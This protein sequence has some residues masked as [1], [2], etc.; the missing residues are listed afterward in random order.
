MSNLIIPGTS[1]TIIDNSAIPTSSSASNNNQGTVLIASASPQGPEKLV[2]LTDVNQFRKMFTNDG[3]TEFKKFGMPLYAVDEVLESGSNVFF[4]RIVSEDA[5]LANVGIVAIVNKVETQKVNAQ[6]LPLYT[7][8]SGEETTDAT[9]V[10]VNPEYKAPV[11]SANKNIT[12]TTSTLMSLEVT[13]TVANDTFTGISQSD[14]IKSWFSTDQNISDLTFTVTTAPTGSN[15]SFTF[16]VGG[17]PSSD[18]NGKLLLTIPAEKI[19]KNKQLSLEFGISIDASGGVATVAKSMPTLPT[20]NKKSKSNSVDEFIT[21]D[22]TPVMISKAS[23]QFA[24][25]YVEGCKDVGDVIHGFDAIFK[26]PEEIKEISTMAVDEDGAILPDAE[27]PTS[28]TDSELSGLDINE[29]SYIFPLFLITEKGRGIGHHRIRIVPDYTNSK[30]SNYFRYKLQ[31]IKNSEVI[32]DT[33]FALD[34]DFAVGTSNKNMETVCADN[35][36]IDVKIQQDW[37]DKFFSV[38]EEFTGLTKEEINEKI[39]IIEGKDKYNKPID[40]ITVGGV[41]LQHTFGIKLSGG[42]YGKFGNTS[43]SIINHPEYISLL[44]KFY[45][46]DLDDDIWRKDDVFFNFVIDCA[47]DNKV[48]RAIENLCE[49]RGDCTAILDMGTSISEFNDF[50]TEKE[51]YKPHYTT[52]IYYQYGEILDKFTNRRITVTLP[53]LIAKRLNNQFVSGLSRPMCGDDYS[54][55]ELKTINHTPKETPNVNEKS[56]L[57]ENRIN[58]GSLY[59]GIFRL[60]TNYT[61]QNAHTQLSYSSNVLAIQSLIQDLVKCAPDMRYRPLTAAE[62]SLTLKQ[63]EAICAR[64]LSDFKQC[65]FE[66]AGTAEDELNKTFKGR[67]IVVCKDFDAREEFDIF[68]VHADEASKYRISNA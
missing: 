53:M 54:F 60:E 42:N 8:P 26:G 50:V 57:V 22:N 63:Y 34:P 38:L 18:I 61:N 48:K 5:T 52:N 44:E 45:N 28:S 37:F 51:L 29:N 35:L 24:A 19:T 56:I 3:T 21:V 13:V 9:S 1:V 40:S 15:D 39:C 66:Y 41:N 23:I 32:S 6:G 64:H 46:G 10:V 65:E 43:N 47:F 62:L 58:Y 25:K 14:D 33:T 4:R 59:N 16:T 12:G 36:Y 68:V 7:T 11:L 49:K 27:L 2:K 17:T 20:T 55:S 30:Y 31:V 67:I